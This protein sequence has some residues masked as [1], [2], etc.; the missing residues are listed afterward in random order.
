[1]LERIWLCVFTHRFCG[2]GENFNPR[3]CGAISDRD[4]LLCRI[5]LFC[6]GRNDFNDIDL[7]RGN[8]FFTNAFGIKTV[9]SPLRYVAVVIM[10]AF[11]CVGPVGCYFSFRKI[12]YRLPF[13]FASLL[14]QV[15]VSRR[16]AFGEKRGFGAF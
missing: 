2:R 11:T 3:R 12:I 9:A 7:Y 5:G 10:Q 8:E 16:V 13:R 15:P 1:V 14:S 4:N 6:N